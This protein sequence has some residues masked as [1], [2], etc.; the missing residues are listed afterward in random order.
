MAGVRIDGEEQVPKF[1]LSDRIVLLDGAVP[2]VPVFIALRQPVHDVVVL[3][4]GDALALVTP[5]D[6][7]PTPEGRRF[8]LPSG[9]RYVI[10]AV[11]SAG[12]PGRRIDI[13]I[14][15]GDRERRAEL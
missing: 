2:L 6:V 15:A 3:D 13:T 8:L 10:Q 5:T 11:D 1:P 12:Q 4:G 9:K 14:G 7:T